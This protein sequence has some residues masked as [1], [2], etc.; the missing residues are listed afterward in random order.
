MVND[1]QLD[2]RRHWVTLDHPEMGLSTYNSPPYRF[3][4]AYSEPSSPAPLLGQHTAE[5]CRDL[6]ALDDATIEKLSAEGVLS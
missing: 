5:I 6:L 3:S 2:Y 4:N 1:P